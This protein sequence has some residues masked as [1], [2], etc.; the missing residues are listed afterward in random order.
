MGGY[1]ECKWTKKKE[2]FVRNVGKVGASLKSWCWLARK[3]SAGKCRDK[4][5][6]LTNK[7]GQELKVKSPEE[8]SVT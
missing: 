2:I 5:I 1:L 6:D 8:R 7:Q 3:I 4:S